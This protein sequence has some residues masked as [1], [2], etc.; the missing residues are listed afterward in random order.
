MDYL[1]KYIKE[2]GNKTF[3]EYKFNEIDALLYTILSYIDLTGLKLNNTPLDKAYS[4]FE[5]KFLLKDKDVFSQ[6]NNEVFKLMAESPRFKNNL[7]EDYTGIINKDMQFGAITINV[8]HHFKFIA[9]EGTTDHLIG[10][11]ENFKM[12]YMYPIPAGIKAIEYL[13]KHIKLNDLLVYIGGH[14]KGGNLAMCAYMELNKMKKWKVNYVFNFDGPGFLKE[15][16]ET[17]KYEQSYKK[18]RSYYPSE[19]IVGMILNT[20]GIKKIITSNKRGINAH[21]AHSWK[22]ED[23]HFIYSELS[24]QSKIFYK[25]IENIFI[26]ISKDKRKEFCETFFKVLYDSGYNFKS[27]LNELH[28]KKIINLIKNTSKLKEDEKKLIIEVF[29]SLFENVAEKA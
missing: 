4:L 8:L 16:I 27:E 23:N 20:K 21:N 2:H 17:K 15:I 24:N 19:S 1:V 22:Y 26:K 29:K 5:R 13:D 10:W 11:E 9:F 12:S 14:S 3:K 28:I 18:F 25:R 6:K 7:I